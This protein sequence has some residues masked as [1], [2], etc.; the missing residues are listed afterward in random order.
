MAISNCKTASSLYYNGPLT[1]R[2]FSS[3]P[4]ERSL[5]FCNNVYVDYK[6]SPDDCNSS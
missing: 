2:T 5:A 1:I 4:I 3:L 6:D